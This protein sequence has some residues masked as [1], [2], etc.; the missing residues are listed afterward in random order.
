MNKRSIFLIAVALVMA[1]TACQPGLGGDGGPT[2]W[3][4]YTN[5]KFG[6]QVQYSPDWAYREF[7]D[8]GTGASF[9]LKT[10]PADVKQI[11]L[12]V[13]ASIPPE[14]Y[15]GQKIADMPF[16]EY[17]RIA[18]VAEIQGFEKLAS[19]EK[20]QAQGVTGYVTTWEYQPIL[21]TTGEK[22]LEISRPIAYFELNKTV[23]GRTYRTLQ[24]R[25]E[26]AAYRA[27]FDTLVRT[28]KLTGQ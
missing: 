24:V 28:V 16:E 4:T 3:L 13:D 25:L 10:T 15:N 21:S 26:D 7:P 19:I 14:Q 6:Y 9:S 1:T 12:V 27:D 22:N 5:A 2:G 20:V 17:V 18:A 23:D 8:R 11:I